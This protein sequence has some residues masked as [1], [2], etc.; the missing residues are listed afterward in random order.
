MPTV[1]SRSS[2]SFPTL[3]AA[4]LAFEGAAAAAQAPQIRRTDEPV[5][6]PLSRLL[7]IGD[8]NGDGMDDFL[9]PTRCDSAG[10]GLYAIT[11]PG[12]ALPHAHDEADFSPEVAAA[13]FNGDG[14]DD[15]VAVNAAGNVAYAYYSAGAPPTNA[16]PATGFAFAVVAG[17]VDG[18]GDRDLI[19]GTSTGDRLYRNVGTGA[20]VW[21]Q[22]SGLSS[23]GLPI[24]ATLAD[25]DGDGFD[26][27]IAAHAGDCKVQRSLGNG[28]FSAPVTL[29]ISGVGVRGAPVVGDVDGDG[30]KDVVYGYLDGSG[31][32]T[33]AL[34]RLALTPTGFSFTPAVS[35]QVPESVRGN[36]V[37]FVP[38][39]R[40]LVD[41]D[42]DGASEIVLG[43]PDGVE[44]RKFAGGILAPPS[45][46]LPLWPEALVP[47]RADE[48]GRTDVAA[49]WLRVDAATTPPTRLEDVR[50]L[51]NDGVG[52][53]VGAGG[54]SSLRRVAINPSL[55]AD[56]DGD[57]D[58]DLLEYSNTGPAGGTAGG[59]VAALNDG[60]G[61][62]SWRSTVP[63]PGCPPGNLSVV[64]RF[65]GVALDADLD[66]DD[67]L[68]VATYFTSA[69]VY[70]YLRNDRA[71]G[72]AVAYTA[73]PATWNYFSVISVDMN[74]DGYPDV[75][76]AGGTLSVHFGGPNGVGVPA[77]V[78]PKPSNLFY[79]DVAALDADLDG[80]LDLIVS[81]TGGAVFLMSND[82]TGGLA[83]TPIS[84]TGGGL[85]VLSASS[86][87]AADLDGDGLPDLVSNG[88]WAKQTS[89]GAFVAMGG[90][91]PAPTT[92]LGR[93]VTLADVDVDGDLDAVASQG[94]VYLN[95]G[96]GAFAV[97]TSTVAVM[98]S[99]AKMAVA[100]VDGDGDPD[101]AE[102]GGLVHTNL[103]RQLSTGRSLRA[104]RPWDFRLHGPPNGA[105]LIAAAPDVLPAPISIPTF[106]RLDLDP[107]AAVIFSS[108][109]LDATGAFTLTETLDAASA[110][111]LGGTVF[112]VQAVIGD[113]TGARLTNARR[114]VAAS[115]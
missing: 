26:D 111:A 9:G 13:D 75:V 59:P 64:H 67:D 37:A 44:I 22:G 54:T 91:L 55:F 48:D 15:V 21:N 58:P 69:P 20:F 17:D 43:G 35:A 109:D 66:G 103:H 7:A 27:L 38:V 19:V 62:F 90:F 36:T 104:A 63:C 100:D 96:A 49:L 33:I 74:A 53:L 45:A 70:A 61:V 51:F 72:F 31:V 23:L 107:G 77:T 1:A 14:L 46:V 84:I 89:P 83:S 18:D 101:L 29:T 5:P 86:L 73:P 106:G 112:I 32:S 79:W 105:W 3:M 114:I 24:G 71:A 110:A 95:N 82:G 92:V 94:G 65:P 93:P 40:A 25:L 11:G 87:E 30:L 41:L 102:G 98:P 97:S 12:P 68:F 81:T 4:L 115:Y 78:I 80:D 85:F 60:R 108:G 34:R 99:L 42:Q 113:A 57:G 10:S 28:S 52:G 88:Y 76:G 2:C 6:T 50:L 56:L 8:F 16:I 47:I 39:A